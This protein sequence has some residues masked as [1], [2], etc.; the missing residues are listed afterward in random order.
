MGFMLAYLG[1]GFHVGIFVWIISLKDI[2]FNH[3]VKVCL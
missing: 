1:L 2:K 3:F